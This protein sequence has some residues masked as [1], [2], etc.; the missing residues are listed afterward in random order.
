MQKRT[1]FRGECPVNQHSLWYQV[2]R[3]LV[4]KS[5]GELVYEE[6]LKTEKQNGKY[7]LT[8]S[9]GV[10]YSFEGAEGVWGSMKVNAD[11]LLRNG[12]SDFEATDFFLDTQ[13]ETGMSDIT[14]AN[15]FEEMHNTLLADLHLEQTSKNVSA[16][17]LAQMP[18]EEMEKYLTGHPK[19][20]L[21]KGR[22]GWSATD[23]S[24]YSPETARPF[25][26][27]WIAVKK[28][29]LSS[30]F[31]TDLLQECFDHEGLKLF[32]INLE[33]KDISL[34]N[35][36][37]LPVHPWQ[38]DRYIETQFIGEISKGIIRPLGFYGDYYLPQTS[39]RTLRNVTRPERMDIKLPVTILNT[40]CFRGLPAR[41]VKI[42]EAVSQRLQE[43]CSEDE[44]L[45]N[46][47][48]LREKGGM[49][50]EHKAW[51]KIKEAPYRYHELLG[52]VF[53]ESARSKLA[54]DEKAI[55]TA[56]L[57]HQ[58]E[59]G[60]ALIHEYIRLSGKSIEEWLRAF[61]KVTLIPL[62][63]LQTKYGVGLVA[64]GQNIVLILKN[65]FPHGMILK[66]FH[67]DLR[68]LEQL[69]PA[70]EKAFGEFSELTRLPKHY[71]IHDLITGSLVTVHR[72]ISLVLKETGFEE[73][74]YYS[75]MTSVIEKE[76]GSELLLREELERVLLNKVR[77][78]IGYGDSAER[79]LPILGNNLINPLAK[80]EEEIL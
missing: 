50:L 67:G 47:R 57:F 3:E 59:K 56:A 79:P 15:F 10:H 44:K 63:H 49:V 19:I 28:G 72:F 13:N 38:W 21:S 75:I 53:R 68:L 76:P 48:I 65:H 35:Y 62:L 23:R 42:G 36:D 4:A 26:L 27:F 22:V 34:K 30:P 9:N 71:L 51:K 14:L 16:N 70:G 77:F 20:L 39:I 43:I 6:V 17:E 29:E 54:H 74:K 80:T 18:G 58:D 24:L 61:F 7:H 31:R 32:L 55:L 11:S 40:S 78:N 73:Q 1:L 60:N 41:Y 52:S 5:I 33:I 66:D 46:V 69:P 8:T 37:L 12:E 64:H 25:Q 45:K 2:N